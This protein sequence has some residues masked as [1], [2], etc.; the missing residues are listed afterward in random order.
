MAPGRPILRSTRYSFDAGLAAIAAAGAGLT[1]LV[2]FV[3]AVAT[4]RAEMFLHLPA[5]AAITAVGAWQLLRRRYRPVLLLAVIE[6]AIV[7]QVALIGSTSIGAAAV[8]LVAVA[9]AGVRLTRRPAPYV[10]AQAV[11]V[12]ATGILWNR[13]MG[14]LDQLLTGVLLAIAFIFGVWLVR[15]MGAEAATGEDRYRSLFESAPIPLWES[16]LT[17]V[18]QRL[19]EL[20]ERGVTDIERFFER[21]PDELA[22]TMRLVKISAVNQA[23]VDFLGARR[24]AILGPIEP[25]LLPTGFAAGLQA[26]ISSVWDG[27]DRMEV[28]LSGRLRRGAP[29]EAAVASVVSRRLGALDVGRVV[30]TLVD[31][32]EAKLSARRLEELVASKDELIAAVSHELRTPLAAV[33]GLSTEMRDRGGDFGRAELAE[34]AGIVAEQSEE[35]A[36]IVD[37]LLVAARH[38]VGDLVVDGTVVDIGPDVRGVVATISPGTPVEGPAGEMWCWADPARVRQ[39]MRNLLVNAQRHGG[40][41]VRVVLRPDGESVTVEVRDDGDPLPEPA[42]ER[43]FDAF[44]SRP[45]S[46]RPQAS[47]GLGLTVSRGLARR[48]GGD[49]TYARDGAESVFALRLAPAAPREPV[50]A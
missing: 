19:E 13:D 7:A 26:H 37:D 40:P 10:T 46:G 34:L 32:T 16:D 47:V 42:V 20:R 9:I 41:Q 29:Y 1:A 48:M 24:E 8:G 33:L 35:L 25:A 11:V 15:F 27:S 39:V 50:R 38:R 6:A 23:A 21:N 30:T 5:A 45:G 28:A 17:Q 18:A 3:V 14:L 31:V 2:F 22:E 49:L 36:G 44:F 12:F 43:L 4:S